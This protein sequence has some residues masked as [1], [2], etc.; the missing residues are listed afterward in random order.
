MASV[1]AAA[2]AGTVVVIPYGIGFVRSGLLLF[3][4]ER[5]VLRERLQTVWICHAARL[6]EEEV[7]V[8]LCDGARW[9]GH[10]HGQSS[11]CSPIRERG[12]GCHVDSRDFV[13]RQISEA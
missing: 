1:V 5:V 8:V 4:T 12:A 11:R 10:G 13:R 6:S 3:P 7:I 2:R 9:I